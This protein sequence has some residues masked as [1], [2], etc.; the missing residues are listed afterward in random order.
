MVGEGLRRLG[1]QALDP[2]VPNMLHERHHRLLRIEERRKPRPIEFLPSLHHRTLA[3]PAG[4]HIQACALGGLH[5]R[6]GN[7][8]A[9]L[10]QTWR[11]HDQHIGHLRILGQ[12]LDGLGVEFRRGIVVQVDGVLAGPVGR[13]QFR[14]GFDGL[15]RQ[16]RQLAT[17][18][19]QPVHRQYPG[20]DTVGHD[21]QR[22]PAQRPHAGQGFQGVEHLP[23]AIHSQH[24]GPL[25]HG[26][27]DRVTAFQAG[28]QFVV[29]PFRFRHPPGLDRNHRLG[30]RRHPHRRHE[31][32]RVGHVLDVQQDGAGLGVLGQIV[33]QVIVIDVHAIAQSQKVGE[34]HTPGK[35]PVQHRTG[36]GAALAHK[37]HA[38]GNGPH[39][40]VGSVQTARRYHQADGVR[41]QHAD[42]GLLGGLTNRVHQR[43]PG[44]AV[45]PGH[46]AGHHDGGSHP[47]LTQPFDGFRDGIRRGTDNRQ[48]RREIHFGHLGHARDSMN[49]LVA[50]LVDHQQLLRGVAAT[51]KVPQDHAP[52]IVGALGS[53]NHDDGTRIEK[54]FQV[55]GAQ[56]GLLRTAPAG[57]VQVI[58]SIKQVTY[59]CTSY[60]RPSGID[61]KR[62][63]RL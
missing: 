37:R 8:Q 3:Q 31:T 12:D 32:P 46:T 40:S 28:R 13:Q 14:Q 19:R 59:L 50:A 45:G 41:P 36:N 61:V 16:L 38:P 63:S 48:I 49:V 15:F 56:G 51:E 62:L 18:I 2:L 6:I 43:L 22:L 4:E 10:G 17:Q 57:P 42:T 30:A 23:Q 24:T 35:G 9:V 25:Q 44:L 60:L 11:V 39:V 54:T 26:I 33:D 7:L 1:Q 47:G 58:T 20:A 5:H 34:P 53:T 55:T 21:R 52:K 27:V 29:E